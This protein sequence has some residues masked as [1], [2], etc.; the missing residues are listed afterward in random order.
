[1]F[2]KDILGDD[3]GNILEVLGSDSDGDEAS[4]MQLCDE[5]NFLKKVI[6]LFS[7]NKKKIK[8]LNL[9][10]FSESKRICRSGW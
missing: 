10:F 2:F 7:I 1:L 6:F 4:F 9:N 8:I 5:A 3:F